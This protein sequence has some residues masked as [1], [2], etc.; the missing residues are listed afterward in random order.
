MITGFC[1]PSQLIKKI[2]LNS[3][4][5]QSGVI[6]ELF[7]CGDAS[8]MCV[9][10]SGALKAGPEDSVA[11]E[12]L[13]QLSLQRG[14]LA[15][16][17]PVEARRQVAVDDFLRPPQDEHASQTRELGRS[18]LSQNSLLLLAV[19]DVRSGLTP[20]NIFITTAQERERRWDYL[21]A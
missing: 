6:T 1:P 10:L 19:E 2:N 4:V 15:K 11:E 8:Q 13:V 5:E 16:Q 9:G 18:L 17:R 12:V 21:C 20:D 3:D 7:Q 14:R